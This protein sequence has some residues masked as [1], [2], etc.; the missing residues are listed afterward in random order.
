MST[1]SRLILVC[2]IGLQAMQMG[3][4][5]TETSKRT[6]SDHWSE[7]SSAK[8]DG[9]S[10]SSLAICSSGQNGCHLP[11]QSCTTRGLSGS[12]RGTDETCTC[13]ITPPSAPSDVVVSGRDATSALVTWSPGD[14]ASSYSLKYCN[15]LSP[16]QCVRMDAITITLQGLTN[17][18]RYTDYTVGVVSENSAGSSVETTTLSL[19]LMPTGSVSGCYSIGAGGYFSNGL[20]HSCGFLGNEMPA[21]CGTANFAI[22]PVR[23]NLGGDQLDGHCGGDASVTGHIPAGHRF[24][25]VGPGEGSFEP[26]RV[27]DV[28]NTAQPV[29]TAQPFGRL[30]SD[31]VRVALADING[32]GVE[33]LICGMGPNSPGRFIVIDGASGSVLMDKTPFSSGG[34][35]VAAGRMLGNGHM[36]VV[37]GAGAGQE[38]HVQVYDGSGSLQS[39]FLAYESTY[40]GGVRVTVG[41]FLGNGSMSVVTSTPPGG[42]PRVRIINPTSG[43]AIVDAFVYDASFRGGVWVAAVD[44]DGDGKAELITGADVGG[45]PHV[46]ILKVTNGQYSDMHDFFAFDPAFR[47]GVRVGA[48]DMNGD[49]KGQLVVA[50]G[51]GGGPQIRVVSGAS[52][53]DT[54][55]S[56]FGAEANSRSGFYVSGSTPSIP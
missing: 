35:Y 26:V 36:Q 9:I 44:V 37:I 24:I 39:H 19:K 46:R 47:G 8:S 6:L 50:A 32:D 14:N 3:C 13:G 20:G 29:L 10:S 22:L 55:P 21:V 52:L 28:K 34:I 27:Y 43:Q 15:L 16:S 4:R 54:V 40:T 17:I 45:G 41:D 11:G 23:T 53:Q 2:T 25:A 48:L 7:A 12:C 31:G 33:D 42:G 30:Y 5:T 49:G 1:F 56:F 51:S 38:P 18:D